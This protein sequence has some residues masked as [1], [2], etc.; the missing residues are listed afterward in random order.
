[1]IPSRKHNISQAVI[2]KR[3][4]RFKALHVNNPDLKLY[5]FASLMRTPEYGT[6]G[7][8]EEP[9]YYVQYG[10][11][12]FNLTALRDK[13]EVEG[14]N[15]NE[16]QFLTY[17]EGSI[18]ND[19]LNDWLER[20]SK[21]LGVTK[22][23]IDLV[24]QE[25]IQ[26]LI[27]GRDDNSPF[28]QTHKENRELQKYAAKY[29]LP[30]TKFQS[31]AG[32]D[33]FG[34]LLLTRAVNDLREESPT[35]N[36]RYNNGKG[37]KTVPAYSDEEIAASIEN[38]VD[39]AGGIIVNNPKW[40]DFV[41]LVNTDPNGKTYQPHNA[42]PNATIKLDQRKFDKNAEAFADIVNEYVTAGYPVGIADII[43]A[44]GSDNALMKNLYDK[45][46]LYKLQAYSGWNTATNST[47]FVIGTGLLAKHMSNK[48]KDRL[49][50]RRYLDD[51]AYQANVRTI[52]GEQ[53]YNSREGGTIYYNLGT[54][55]PA[56][57]ERLTV[58]MRD[59]AAKHLP[60]FEYLND[61]TVTLPWNRMFECAINF[62]D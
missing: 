20:R 2:N 18:P 46:L 56:V 14:L 17:L 61:F 47:G 38:A 31:L 58:L 39:I 55:T 5:I 59:F 41:L 23:F 13:A 24:D 16:Q 9:D 22:Q 52:I 49:L 1:M 32:I 30:K 7:F 21:N 53:L 3:M 10:N 36:I 12:I 37:E 15:R 62:N 19:V 29:N 26:Y 60:P 35:I 40:A 54:H 4:E 48:S 43:F 11:N 44:N 8:T 51:W 34:I 50:T 57:E 27:V 45:G 25:V 33:E 6:A 28:C 42:L